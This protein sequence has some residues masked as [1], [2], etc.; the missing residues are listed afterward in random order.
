MLSRRF[1]RMPSLST[2]QQAQHCIQ[3]DSAPSCMMAKYWVPYRI[4]WGTNTIRIA[5]VGQQRWSVAVLCSDTS[6]VLV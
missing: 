4:V 3:S 1:C 2:L 6:T 5:A